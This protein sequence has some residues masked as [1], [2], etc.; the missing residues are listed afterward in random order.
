MQQAARVSDRTAF[1]TIDG[2]GMPG[3]VVEMDDTNVIFS[4]PTQQ[5]TTD[6]VTGR[7]G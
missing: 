3:H 4:N 5:K 6:Y 2:T 1:F 7:F